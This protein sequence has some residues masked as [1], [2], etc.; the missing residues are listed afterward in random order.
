[1][2][3]TVAMPTSGRLN[4]LEPCIQSLSKC[5]GDF[6][7]LIFPDKQTSFKTIN[8][9]ASRHS[10]TFQVMQ[11]AK[12]R[13]YADA[14]LI[15]ARNIAFEKGAD[16]VLLMDDDLIVSRLFVNRLEVLHK[17]VSQWGDHIVQSCIDCVS[18]R[19][20]K[21]M[22]RDAVEVGFTTGTNSLMSRDTWT[23]T[24]PTLDE[25]VKLWATGKQAND[26]VGI[27]RWFQKLVAEKESMLGDDRDKYLAEN[28]GIASDAA[29]QVAAIVAQI[30][31]CHLV[32]NRAV[33]I[34]EVGANFTPEIFESLRHV[35]LDDVDGDSNRSQFLWHPEGT[36]DH[37]RQLK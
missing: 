30:R 35:K 1:M 19:I 21:E 34:G 8:D 7:V 4:Y 36:A 33:T 27:R 12:D 13:Q 6:D 15:G 3:L 32:V 20:L 22:M 26:V 25:Y 11:P 14:A 18:D 2:K 24:K 37:Y 16:M 10:P 29:L 17:W 31:T 23:K 9:I 28:Y 5:I